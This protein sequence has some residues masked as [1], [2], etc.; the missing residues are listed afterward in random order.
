[1]LHIKTECNVVFFKHEEITFAHELIFLFSCILLAQYC[2]KMLQKVG[3]LEKNL[4]EGWVDF[5]RVAYIKGSFK[6][7][8]HYAFKGNKGINLVK[9]IYHKTKPSYI[10]GISLPS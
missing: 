6:P 1:M 2:Q 9:I 5:W 3:G 10:T 8:A 7:S 4:N